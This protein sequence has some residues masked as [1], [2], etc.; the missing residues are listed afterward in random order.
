[1]PGKRGFFF[2][3]E[4]SQKPNLSTEFVSCLQFLLVRLANLQH[5]WALIGGTN[6]ALQGINVKPN[7][8]DIITTKSGIEAI[9]VNLKI[10]EK[11][12]LLFQRNSHIQSWFTIFEFENVRIEVMA[13]VENKIKEKW[14][15]HAK[16]EN[17]VIK[18]KF[19]SCEIPCLSLDYEVELYTILGF[20]ER[21]VLLRENLNQPF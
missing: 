4:I 14:I 5:P 15:P 7:D 3:M 10:I 20:S 8:I 16:W 2:C 21:V 19:D 12:P 13:D 1:M 11:E 9:S 17:N 6:H 18:T